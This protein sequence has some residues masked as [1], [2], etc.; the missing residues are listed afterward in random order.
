MVLGILIPSS[1]GDFTDR[2]LSVL[3]LHQALL[4]VAKASGLPV[5]L[6]CYDPEIGSLLL[7]PI[8]RVTLLKSLIL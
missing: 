3:F 6:V 7:L 2:S 4:T 1:G 5:L 8:S